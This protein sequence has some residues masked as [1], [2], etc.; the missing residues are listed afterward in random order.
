[1][2]NITKYILLATS[3]GV[4]SCDPNLE[5]TNP[6]QPTMEVFWQNSTDAEQ[7]VNSIYST[8]ARPGM[9]RWM[10]MLYITRSDE[11]YSGSPWSDLAN[12]MGGF[13]Q[14][15]YNFGPVIDVWVD[16]YVGIFRANQVIDNVPEIEMENALKNRLLGEAYY[17]RAYFYYNLALLWGNVPMLLEASTPTDLPPTSPQAAVW[18]Q[19]ELDLS[20]AIDGLP[21]VYPNSRDLGR[22]TK[23]AAHALLAKV[24]MQQGK[25]NEAETPLNWLVTG[26]GAS[27]YNLVSD[28]RDNFKITSENNQESVF[29]WQYTINPT[30]VTDNDVDTPNHNYGTSISQFLAPPGI[31][32]ADAEARTWPIAE[33][34]KEQT[35]EGGRD[36]RLSASYIYA[37]T[38]ERG[39]EFTMVYGQTFAKRY[40]ME[41]NRAFLRKF[42]NDHWRNEEGYRGP[43]N[44]RVIR[45]ADVLLMYAEVLNATGRTNQAYSHVDRVRARVG[46]PALSSTKPGLG[47]KEFL[48]QLK[49]ERLLELS[50]EGHRWADLARWGD[51]GKGLAPRDPGFNNFIVGRHEFLPIPQRDLD[52]NKNLNQNPGW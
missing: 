44:Y 35:T 50:G 18:A 19:I 52:I 31:G 16:C 41:N 27:I 46:L 6:N 45:Y 36:P 39:P 29:E 48:L 8:F 11:G 51:L 9:S 21:S 38:D 42:L 26:E 3:C 14:P 20:R 7:G 10:P 4:L 12:A 5:I 22:V 30:E 13:I 15:D 34:L 2:K 17:L 24:L 1:M 23:G 32:W 43:N 40:G 37:D 33:F 49:H 47:P 28:Y 25:F